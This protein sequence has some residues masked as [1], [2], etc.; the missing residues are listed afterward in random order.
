MNSC[1]RVC[2]LR[3]QKIE[4]TEIYLYSCLW[5]LN[6]SLTL[7][8]EQKIRVLENEVRGELFLPKWEEVT[9][10]RREVRMWKFDI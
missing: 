4:Y 3:A 5:A 10:E 8:E 1:L 7:K 2:F 9:D 6:P